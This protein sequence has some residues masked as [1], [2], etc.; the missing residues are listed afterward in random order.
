MPPIL[1]TTVPELVAANLRKALQEGRWSGNLPGVARLAVEL[2]VS[3]HTIRHALRMLESEG[4]LGARGLGR[5]RSIIPIEVTG[6]PLRLGI[7]LHDARPYGQPKSTPLFPPPILLMI[8]HVLE[9]AGHEVFFARQSQV[10]LQHDSGRI[11]NHIAETP[12]AAWLV[13]AGSRDVLEWFAA[14]PLPCIALFGRVG[15]LSLARTG[16]DKVPAFRETTRK[17]IELGHRRI[18]LI[19]RHGRRLPTAGIAERA[20]L[21][22][23]AAHGITAGAYNLPDWQESPK[24]FS[25]LLESLFRNTPPTALILDEIGLY[26]AAAE[27]LARRGIVVPSQVSLVSTD[28]DES[29][30]W[31]YPGIAH[32]RWDPAPVVRHVARWVA[33]VRKGRVDRT[34]HNFPAE[35]VLGGSVGPVKPS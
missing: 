20:F 29:M 1:R 25:V 24:G 14:Q 8:Q 3:L 35:F 15:G 27:F 6:R 10:D 19:A 12:A 34:T 18:V 9:T 33:A 21:A 22:E 4:L 31:C 30:A 28:E 16:P 11:S 26:I 17:L 32:I 2:D 7:L 13:E 23:L 5:S